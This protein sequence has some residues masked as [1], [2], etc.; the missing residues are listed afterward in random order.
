MSRPMSVEPFHSSGNSPGASFSSPAALL[1][2]EP[3]CKV[4]L[5]GCGTVGSAV[6]RRLVSH[7]VPGLELICILDR[8]AESKARALALEAPG[9]VW[10]TRFEDVLTSDADVVVEL[11]GGV[12]PAA[13]WTRRAAHGGEVGRHREQAGRRP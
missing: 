10:T 13:D 7:R 1:P 9:L 12:D 8:R 4:A 2:V 5:L 3:R 11:V 6:A